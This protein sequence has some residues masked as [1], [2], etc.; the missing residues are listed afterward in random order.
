M[1]LLRACIVGSGPAGFY[2]AK[3]LM[4]SYPKVKVDMFES[5]PVPFGLVRY[6]VAPDHQ[7]VKNV[8]NTFRE[9]ALDKRFSFYGNVTIGNNI[10]KNN[11]A[12]YISIDELKK[13]YHTI[14]FCIGANGDKKLNIPGENLNN[15]YTSR[16]FINWYNGLPVGLMNNKSFS[17]DNKED[18]KSIKN[19]CIIGQGNVAL[20]CARMLISPT[21]LLNSTDI[22]DN[23]LNILKQLDL[24]KINIIGRR[25]PFQ[26]QFSVGEVREIFKLNTSNI[27]INQN[28]LIA[29]NEH[30]EYERRIKRLMKVFNDYS[31]NTDTN[32][33]NNKTDLE[34]CFFKR[35]VEI[36]PCNNDKDKVGYLKLEKMALCDTKNIIAT[37]EYETISCDLLISSV[38][39][40]VNSIDGLPKIIK[41]NCIPNDNSKIIF[42][43]VNEQGNHFNN[44]LYACGWFRR[45]PSGVILTNIEEAN[46][47]VNRILNDI[48]NG[49]IDLT[50]N[51][52]YQ[53]D[54]HVL[55]EVKGIDLNTIVTWED[56]LK[57]DNYEMKNGKIKGKIREKIVD[58]NKMLEIAKS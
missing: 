48:D 3:K 18:I 55:N 20:D 57:I 8:E 53:N 42:T 40:K 36:L 45:G 52:N 56:F 41:D 47:T 26:A 7:K 5:L 16:N 25:G 10:Y 32:N 51:I 50:L 15:V 6:G 49:I 27:I 24:K 12:N 28:D 4:K 9:I 23:S 43:D 44:G 2:T 33:Y 37:G 14:V 11:I 29:N 19:V 31:K 46:L 13:M 34:L 22:T 21:N 39:Y 35:P 17:F 58:I 1:N 38:G 54:K 30:I